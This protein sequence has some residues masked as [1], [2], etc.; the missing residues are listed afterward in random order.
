MNKDNELTENLNRMLTESADKESVINFLR[1]SN[2]S[3]AESIG[4]L[5]KA[6]GICLLEAQDIIHNSQT[7]SDVKERDAKINNEFCDFL[8][9][10]GSS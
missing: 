10:L 6:L 7:W 2:Y 8:E 1:L 3:K 9:G 5:N 4:I